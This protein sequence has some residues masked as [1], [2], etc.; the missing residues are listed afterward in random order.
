MFLGQ[1]LHGIRCYGSLS[2]HQGGA[3]IVGNPI[4]DLVLRVLTG[5]KRLE[6]KMD[7]LQIQLSVASIEEK[8]VQSRRG[9]TTPFR[10]TL[11]VTSARLRYKGSPHLAY[12][13][14][15]R[16]L[17]SLPRRKNR[18][19]FLGSRSPATFSASNLTCPSRTCTLWS[20]LLLPVVAA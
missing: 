19:G 14:I 11:G 9:N 15:L 1:D 20:Y 16:F 6:D 5:M 10:R 13:Q 2:G 8:E 3:R 12:V 17:H 4:R 18:K 7:G